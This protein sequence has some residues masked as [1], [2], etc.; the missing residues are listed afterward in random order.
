MHLTCIVS[1]IYHYSIIQNNFPALKNPLCFIYLNYTWKSG[2]QWSLCLDNFVFLECHINRTI[3]CVA[4]HTGCFPLSMLPVSYVKAHFFLLYIPFYGRT[5]VSICISILFEAHLVC[6]QSG[7]VMNKAD[8][9]CS[10]R[11]VFVWT[12]FF[13]SVR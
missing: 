13:K 7:P 3:E 1:L 2:Q 10:Q 11:Q 4:F 9:I 6:L 5:T 12:L 8:T